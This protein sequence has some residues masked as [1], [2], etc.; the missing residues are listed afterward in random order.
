[1]RD[2]RDSDDDAA[3]PRNTSMTIANDDREQPTSTRTRTPD[4]SITTAGSVT[5][6]ASTAPRTTRARPALR[7]ALPPRTRTAVASFGKPT[8]RN[9]LAHHTSAFDENSRPSQKSRELSP[10]ARH[11]FTRFAQS[12]ALVILE[13]LIPRAPNR[14][15]AP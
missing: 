1:M 12:D 8:R 2:H 4:S 5:R 9:R 6:A 11:S 14:Y 7:P 10:L 13:S 15:T 3:P